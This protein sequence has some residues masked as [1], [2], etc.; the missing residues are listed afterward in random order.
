MQEMATLTYPAEGLLFADYDA[1]Y[2]PGI[3][4][5]L[6]LWKDPD[7][8][9]LDFRIMSHPTGVRMLLVGSPLDPDASYEVPV[10][11]HDNL[12]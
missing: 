3:N 11:D 10:E 12:P 7:S 5:D 6:F 1:K 2:T 9:T 4:P 8:Y